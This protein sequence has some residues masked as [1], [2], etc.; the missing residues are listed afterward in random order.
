[1]IFVTG[2]LLTRTETLVFQ[3]PRFVE[4]EEEGQASA[5]L[6]QRL[7]TLMLAPGEQR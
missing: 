6:F 2:S 5:G 1:M 4:E 7:V 3:P